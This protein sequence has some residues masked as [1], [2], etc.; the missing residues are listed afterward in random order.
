MSPTYVSTRRRPETNRDSIAIVKQGAGI[1]KARFIGAAIFAMF[2]LAPAAPARADVV[3]TPYI[4]S[5]F[6]GDMS[7]NTASFGAN[8]AFMGG[9]IFGAEVGFNYAP[10]FVKAGVKTTTSPR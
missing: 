3:L 6:G 10:E 5:L 4:G 1:T 8:A 9:G 7:E 2:L